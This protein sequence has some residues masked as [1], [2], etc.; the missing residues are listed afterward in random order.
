V[1]VAHRHTTWVPGFRGLRHP[2]Q[3]LLL[4]ARGP[5]SKADLPEYETELNW[6]TGDVI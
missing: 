6:R 1:Y 4:L 5:D 3:V 2:G